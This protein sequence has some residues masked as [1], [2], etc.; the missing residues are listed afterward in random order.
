MTAKYLPNIFFIKNQS[1]LKSLSLIPYSVFWAPTGL[2][3]VTG[4]NIFGLALNLFGLT[5]GFFMWSMMT[6]AMVI[7]GL[8]GMLTRIN[9]ENP[10]Q[11][12]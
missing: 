6:V 8:S 3:A 2:W 5:F 7:A 12:E 9:K 4:E 11:D 1:Y 10:V